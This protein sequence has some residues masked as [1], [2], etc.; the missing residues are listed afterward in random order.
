[1]LLERARAA[2][3]GLPLAA[4]GRA[5]EA[6]LP[7]AARQ[8]LAQRARQQPALATQPLALGQAQS[9]QAAEPELD[10]RRARRKQMTESK[11]RTQRRGMSIDACQFTTEEKRNR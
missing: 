6:G 10:L 4:R 9:L 1:V 2:K 7:L 3:A 8:A 11:A 5:A